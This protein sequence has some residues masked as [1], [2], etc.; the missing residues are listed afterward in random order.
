MLKG[1]IE[2]LG[3]DTTTGVRRTVAIIV[4]I[5]AL[6]FLV[7]IGWITIQYR[8]SN[9][10]PEIREVADP[11]F[12]WTLLAVVTACASVIADGAERRHAVRVAQAQATAQAA[13]PAGSAP[14]LVSTRTWRGTALAGLAII[15]F[16]LALVSSNRL[17]HLRSTTTFGLREKGDV[18]ACAA[19]I[20]APSIA[21]TEDRVP[22]DLS[23][24]CKDAAPQQMPPVTASFGPETGGD[25]AAKVVTSFAGAKTLRQNERVWRWFVK[26]GSGEQPLDVRLTFVGDS[27][28]IPLSRVVVSQPTTLASLQEQTTALGGLLGALIGVLGTLGSLFKS[29]RGGSSTVVAPGE[30]S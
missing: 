21:T 18:K 19:T 29:W 24:Y 14:M 7:S 16:S 28:V 9:S 17:G 25:P 4:I 23:V 6:V 11:I 13:A 3:S 10:W 30:T 5:A 1:V 2:Q 20:L 8:A 26:F 15:A 27:I 22:I 12:A